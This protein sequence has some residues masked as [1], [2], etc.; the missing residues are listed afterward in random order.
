[1]RAS[2][3]QSAGADQGRPNAAMGRC[4]AA[5]LLNL[6]GGERSPTKTSTSPRSNLPRYAN[7]PYSVPCDS[8]TSLWRRYTS[9]HVFLHSDIGHQLFL[10]WQPA[11][12]T[13]TS[14][15]SGSR[16]MGYVRRAPYYVQCIRRICGRLHRPQGL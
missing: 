12:M 11:A 14:S 6:E 9:L 16:T 5:P 2:E 15:T 10:Y 1:M 8:C 13:A 7:L 4:Q 3:K